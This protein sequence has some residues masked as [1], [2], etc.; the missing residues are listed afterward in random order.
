MHFSLLRPQISDFFRFIDMSEGHPFPGTGNLVKFARGLSSMDVHNN[1]VIL[2]DNDCEGV[3]ACGRIADLSLPT[4]MR[5]V[6]LPE[7]EELRSIPARGP[8]GVKLADINKRAASIECYLDLEVRG[9]P[10]VEIVWTN[11]K[12]NLDAYQG[13]LLAKEKYTKRFLKQSLTSLSNGS[14]NVAKLTAVLDEIY[15]TCRTMV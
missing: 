15:S 1:V 4:N 11:Y 8:Q 10:P 13:A 5:A 9:L 7:L 6:V 14:Y 2:L 12:S 3:E